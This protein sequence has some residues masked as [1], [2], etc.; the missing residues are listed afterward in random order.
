M[1]RALTF[2]IFESRG[3]GVEACAGFRFGSVRPGREGGEKNRK[4]RQERK[5]RGAREGDG[6]R[7]A[8]EIE[9]E[10]ERLNLLLCSLGCDRHITHEW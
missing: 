6:E 3:S 4:T 1:S 9:R 5:R 7:V 2:A 8:G 10:R